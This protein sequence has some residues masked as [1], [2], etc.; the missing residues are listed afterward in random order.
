MIESTIPSGRALRA[1]VLALSAG[2]SRRRLRGQSSA[3]GASEL[4]TAWEFSPG[5][6]SRSFE[7]MGR[8]LRGTVGGVAE[9]VDRV[10]NTA[11]EL[12]LVSQSVA[13]VTTDQVAGTRQAAAA[14]NS[15]NEQVREDL[16]RF[17]L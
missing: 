17:R 3:H 8:S 11:G 5:G 7:E 4:R 14:M 2:L 15:L 16:D 1:R 9:T 12:A 13:A 6:L 10:E